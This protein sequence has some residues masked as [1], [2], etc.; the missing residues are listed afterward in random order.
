V[1]YYIHA[2]IGAVG[3]AHANLIKAWIRL[4]LAV[5]RRVVPCLD[6][7]LGR[8]TAPVLVDVLAAFFPASW[9]LLQVARVMSWH[10]G[11]GHVIRPAL[12]NAI[13]LWVWG[14]WCHTVTGTVFINRQEHRSGVDVGARACRGGSISRGGDVL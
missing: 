7:F 5:G 13:E 11:L 6:Y 3:N 9:V 4:V 10:A 12:R 2:A 8:S 1:G 14:N